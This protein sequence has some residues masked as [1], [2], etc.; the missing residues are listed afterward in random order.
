MSFHARLNPLIVKNLIACRWI[1]VLVIAFCLLLSS[2]AT[3]QYYPFGVG[4]FSV[5]SDPTAIVSGDFNGD[6]RTDLA[7]TSGNGISVLLGKPDGSFDPEVSYSIAQTAPTGLALADLNGDGR[8]DLIAVVASPPSVA[9]LLGNGNGTFQAATSVALPNLNGASSVAVGDFNKDGRMDLAVVG[10]EFSGSVA[11]ILL[12][13][14]NGSFSAEVDYPTEGWFRVITGDFNGDGNDD[15]VVGDNGSGQGDTL[16]ILLGKGDGTFGAFSSISLD[17][18]ENDS[19]AAADLNHDGKLDLVVAPLYNNLAGGFSVLIGNGDGSFSPAVFYPPPNGDSAT[20]SVVISDF[21]G[22]GKLDVVCSDPDSNHLIVFLGVGDGTFKIPVDY[23]ASMSP[24]AII[25]GDFNGDGWQD[26]ASVAASGSIAA[27]TVLIGRGDG[28]F[29]NHVNHSV[30]PYPYDLATGDFNGDGIPDLVVDSFNNPGSVSILLGK[31]NGSFLSHKD[32]KV[33]IAPTYLATGDFNGDGSLDVVV[34]AEDAK[35]GMTVLST[36][37]GKGNGTLQSPINQTIASI[38]SNFAVADFNLDG[39]L[40]LATCLQLTDS[41]AVFLG[42]G[43]GT[44]A[45]PSFFDT[46][47]STQNIGPVYSADLNGDHKPDL[48]VQ[49]FA[50]LSI[51]IA[52]LLGKGNGSFHPFNTVLS[53]YALLG[54]GDFNGDGKP[55]LVVSSD[56]PGIGIALG[57]G[58]GTFQDPNITALPNFLAVEHPVIGDFNG[59]GKLDLAFVSP[60]DSILSVLLGNGDGTFESRSDYL[61]ASDPLALAAADFTNDGGLDL[62][63]A[64]VGIADAGEVSVHLNRPVGALYPSSLDFGSQKVGTASQLVATL[65]NSGGAPLAISKIT[66]SGQFT[67]T[68]TCGAS[69]S[70]GSSCTISIAFKPTSAGIKKGKLSIH[71]NST[72]KPQILSF[73]G[74]GVK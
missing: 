66:I 18:G 22:D 13:K 58:D 61:T 73:S 68:S 12:N 9:I 24:V 20:N 2:I 49:Q 45:A 40:D 19:L 48:V 47:T 31:G 5:G 32:T 41:V 59:D 53:G 14:G 72:A 60:S 33:G 15:L 57:K 25:A 69:L 8:L 74:V 10:W 30:P 17:S 70:I 38:P 34:S 71:D 63:V 43:D 16:S 44:F 7:V 39:N 21:N 51:G 56:P 26:I 54:I 23:S 42:N 46:G 36:L 4:A 62:A 67:Q 64:A 65:Y 28:T 29:T 6:G 3:A 27:V 11:A 52:V 1:I 37:L 55:D 35:S 50:T